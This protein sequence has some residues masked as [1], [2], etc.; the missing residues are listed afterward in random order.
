MCASFDISEI[1]LALLKD[2]GRNKFNEYMKNKY[3]Y[4][5]IA[6]L[7]KCFKYGMNNIWNTYSEI[8]QLSITY[9]DNIDQLPMAYEEI[10]DIAIETMRESNECF[11]RRDT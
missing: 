9:G 2:K 3:P 8:A 6:T 7:M 1:E 10:V 5:D 11:F 4:M